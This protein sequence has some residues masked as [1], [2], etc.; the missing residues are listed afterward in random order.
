[1]LS[2]VKALPRFAAAIAVAAALVFGTTQALAG[3]P[4]TPLPPHSCKY[5]PQSGV[6]CVGFCV[7]NGYPYGGECLTGLD[8]CLCLEK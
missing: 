6:D 4:C 7:T 8:C 3:S 2:R 5:Y 1:M